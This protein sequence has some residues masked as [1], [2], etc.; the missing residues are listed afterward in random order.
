MSPTW[1]AVLLFAVLPGVAAAQNRARTPVEGTWK[2]TEIV[3]T[4]TGAF[5]N[6]APQ[7]G[8]F[9]FTPTH[10]SFLYVPDN[11][12]R[13]LF[14]GPVATD[15]E[16][17]RAFDSF[18]AN[19]GTYVISGTTVMLRP[20]AARVPNC[21]TGASMR[22]Q[23]TVDSAALLLTQKN[24]DVTCVYGGQMASPGAGPS[25]SRLRLVRVE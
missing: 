21:G 4:G 15:S 14:E 1:R 18:L 11:E 3:V 9:I 10:Y 12:A 8:L 2:V 17:L 23:F 6:A 25:E 16:K 22:L 24:T 19:V 7:P 13:A 20:I 5:R